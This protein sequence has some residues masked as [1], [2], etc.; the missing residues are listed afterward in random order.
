MRGCV[1]IPSKLQCLHADNISHKRGNASCAAP[2][3]FMPVSNF[4]CTGKRCDGRS[5]CRLPAARSSD[6][7]CHG[8]Q[9]VGVRLWATVP[10]PP[11]PS[12]FRHQRIR[13]LTPVPRS[14]RPSAALVTPSHSAPLASRVRAHFDRTVTV[15]IGFDHRANGDAGADVLLYRVKIVSQRGQRNFRPSP[16]VENQRAALGHFRQIG[17]RRV[18]IVDYSERV[19]PRC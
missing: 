15:A 19:G 2:R 11:R 13:A 7:M 5:S 8:S 9:I 16:A 12:R 10:P 3:R 17:A 6:S 1:L 18:H 14:A 4:R